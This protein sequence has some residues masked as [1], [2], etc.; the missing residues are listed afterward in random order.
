MKFGAAFCEAPVHSKNA[1][2]GMNQA[3]TETATMFEHSHGC[4][5]PWALLSTP[6]LTQDSRIVSRVM[7]TPPT[8][9]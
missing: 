4:H 1:V 8:L 6:S 5:T 9:Q 3:T 2:S 7:D